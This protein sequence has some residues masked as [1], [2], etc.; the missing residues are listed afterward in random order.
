MKKR[1]VLFFAIILLVL[2]YM[3][4]PYNYNQV[5]LYWLGESGKN[6]K[7]TVLKVVQ[8]LLGPLATR[9]NSELLNAK[10]AA[11]FKKDD[12][13]AATDGRSL[14]IFNEIDERM[15]VST[16]NIRDITEGGRDEFGN[17]IMTTVRPAYSP[18]Y[19]VN[20][21]GTP[22]VVANSLLNFEIGRAHV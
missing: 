6:G 13:L 17:R 12:S 21:A 4:S 22:L 16:Q 7:S 8:D 14:L 18:N 20:I 10:P 5:L 11:S 2:A 15:V 19:E 3:M 1:V 9:M